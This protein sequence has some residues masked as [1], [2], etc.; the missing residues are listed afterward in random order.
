M[1]IIVLLRNINFIQLLL[2]V[3]FC[4]L[5]F[6]VFYDTIIYV[7]YGC[8]ELADTSDLGSGAMRC[9]R[10]KS[11]HPYHMKGAVLT[12][13]NVYI[14][15]N[16]KLCFLKNQLPK[17]Y[18]PFIVSYF[19]NTFSR[20]NKRPYEKYYSSEYSIKNFC[21]SVYMKNP[22]FQNNSIFISNE[23]VYLKISVLDDEDAIDMYNAFLMSVGSIYPTPYNN[24]FETIKVTIENHKLIYNN[25]ILIKML[26]PI[27]V[28][29]VE[30]RKNTYYSWN[31]EKFIPHLENIVKNSVEAIS[32]IKS[33]A[34]KYY[35]GYA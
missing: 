9:A 33:M 34:N 14:Y 18:R 4:I 17:D 32:D 7:V 3:Y 26:S 16:L 21:F 15:I 22:S 24:S 8:G 30:K 1:N 31:D 27:L 25:E 2:F 29:S 35:S 11:C 5:I 10:F 28:R 12:Y 13:T 19:K 20:Y 23:Y 6:L